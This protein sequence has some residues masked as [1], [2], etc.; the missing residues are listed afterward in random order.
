MFG[1][2]VIVL[3]L[4][5]LAVLS[6]PEQDRV[7]FL[8]PQY[9]GRWYSGTSILIKDTSMSERESSIMFFLN[10]FETLTMILLFFGLMVDQGAQA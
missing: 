8:V 9:A 10:Q 6:A 2:A 1:K 4:I 5:V 3:S 7:Y